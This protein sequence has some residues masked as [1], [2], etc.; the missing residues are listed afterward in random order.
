MSLTELLL[1]VA[2]TGY[3]VYRQTQRSQVDGS[4]RFKLAFIYGGIGL[5]AGGLYLPRTPMGIGLFV[6]S[7]ALSVI[8]GL[9]R[10]RLTRV[11]AEAGHVYSQGTALTVSLFLG[12]V[13][14]KF[15]LGTLAYFLH[16][17]QHSGIGEVLLMIAVMIAFQAEIIWRR[18][19]R[20]LP[21]V[22]PG[23]VEAPAH[24]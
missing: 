18:A 23:A 11:W 20:L 3:A 4:A 16:A 5:V 1:I 2:L 14:A 19:R 12:L 13:I 15:G 6:V 7:M 9:L 10:G 17:D 22:V 8:V 24:V 21:S